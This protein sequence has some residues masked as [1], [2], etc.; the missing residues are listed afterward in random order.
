MNVIEQGFDSPRLQVADDEQLIVL[1]LETN[2]KT[3]N[4]SITFRLL[5]GQCNW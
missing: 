4:A 3:N 1:N 5:P 2:N